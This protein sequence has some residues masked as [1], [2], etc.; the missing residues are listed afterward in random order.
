MSK[1]LLA[2]ISLFSIFSNVTAVDVEPCLFIYCTP[3]NVLSIEMKTSDDVSFLMDAG[4]TLERCELWRDEVCIL[5]KLMIEQQW[6]HMHSINTPN[7]NV[8]RIPYCLLRF[9]HVYREVSDGIS[10]VLLHNR[11]NGIHHW[12]HL[13]E[14][15]ELLIQSLR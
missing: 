11:Y 10:T 6:E 7:F 2:S 3:S 12:L 14:R 5:G 13:K 1:Y 8:K 15:A 4:N 9:H